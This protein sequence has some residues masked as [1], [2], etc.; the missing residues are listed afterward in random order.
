MPALKVAGWTPCLPHS[1][2]SFIKQ[3]G[4][5]AYCLPY[6]LLFEASSFGFFTIKCT[7]I[8]RNLVPVGYGEYSDFSGWFVL[9][10]DLACLQYLAFLCRTMY[11]S[12]WLA[13]GSHLSFIDN[14]FSFPFEDSSQSGS[15]G[16]QSLILLGFLPGDIDLFTIFG[17]KSTRRRCRYLTWSWTLNFNANSSS[18]TV[19]VLS[20]LWEFLFELTPM[21]IH[22]KLTPWRLQ[23]FFIYTRD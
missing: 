8:M 15:Q 7:S 1:K 19:Q 11:V 13:S 10:S 16:G 5:Y 3:G 12:F 17:N 6:C 21:P 2:A 4:S 18:I 14:I 9:N 22:V 23:W 20:G